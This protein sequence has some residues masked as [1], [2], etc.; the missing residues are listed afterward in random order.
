MNQREESMV[1]G[2][3][4]CPTCNGKMYIISNASDDTEQ[5]QKC[6]DCNFYKDDRDA[7]EAVTSG[8]AIYTVSEKRFLQWMFS[9]FESVKEIGYDVAFA[10]KRDG[11]FTTTTEYQFRDYDCVPSH[12][13]NEY[14][15][16][17]L[18]QTH[19]ETKQII[20]IK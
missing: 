11:V 15:Y 13:V 12:L 10:L 20:L 18:E 6:D 8:K 1:G 3:A 17:H 2:D 7:Y 9:N 4:K 14:A 16:I 19:I 5:I